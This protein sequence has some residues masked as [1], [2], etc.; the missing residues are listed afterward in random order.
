[1]SENLG[2]SGNSVW[3]F[4]FYWTTGMFCGAIGT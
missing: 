2:Y 4:N 1:M 3:K